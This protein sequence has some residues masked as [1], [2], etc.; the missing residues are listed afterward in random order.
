IVAGMAEDVINP[1]FANGPNLGY[2]WLL[3]LLLF[4]DMLEYRQL[5]LPKTLIVRKPFFQLQ[6]RLGMQAIQFFPSHFAATYQ[7]C[8]TKDLQVFGNSRTA[9]GKTSCYFGDG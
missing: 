5:V 9:H 6:Q 3:L 8:L 7:L 2:A 1:G 4:D